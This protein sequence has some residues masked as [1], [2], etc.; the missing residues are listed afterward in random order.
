MT[1]LGRITRPRITY[2]FLSSCCDDLF[3]VAGDHLIPLRA[4]RGRTVAP[5]RLDRARSLRMLSASSSSVLVPL[6]ASS[7]RSSVSVVASIASAASRLSKSGGVIRSRAGSRAGRSPADRARCA[8]GSC[9]TPQPP[10]AGSSEQLAG[11]LAS[12]VEFAQEELL[13]LVRVIGEAQPEVARPMVASP[14]RRCSIVAVFG[15]DRGRVV[16]TGGSAP[17]PSSGRGG[18]CVVCGL[19]VMAMPSSS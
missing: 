19:S 14:A 10:A 16:R 5:E 3:T 8:S 4:R 9:R 6:H 15:I 1:R 7:M 2:P 11:L 18:V 12:L 13:R 17:R